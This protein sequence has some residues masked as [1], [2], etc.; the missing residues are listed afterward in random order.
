[1]RLRRQ[2]VAAAGRCRG[3]APTESSKPPIIRPPV[4]EL[5]AYNTDQVVVAVGVGTLLVFP[6][7]L[8]HSVDANRSERA[9]IS[10]SFNAMFTAFASIP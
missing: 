4:T 9:R 7:W 5:T 2:P 8:P 3:C 1:M 10:I 6:A